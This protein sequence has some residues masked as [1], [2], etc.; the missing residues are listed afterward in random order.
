[1]IAVFLKDLRL[2]AR[3]R[4]AL[5]FALVVPILVITTI[6]AALYDRDGGPNLEILVVDE[7]RGPVASD[8]AKLL[9]NHAEVRFAER[10]EAEIAV[11]VKNQVPAA[12]V[13]PE[14]LS[15]RYLQGRPSEITLLTDPAQATGINTLKVLLLLMDKDAAALADPL[16]EEMVSVEEVNLTGNRL[17]V[18]PFEQNVPGFSLMFVLLAVVFGT[19]TGLHDE[20]DWGTLPRLLVAPA[21]F[22]WMLLG[23]LGARWL[24]GVLQMMVLLLWGRAFFG[25]SLGASPTAFLL[26]CAVVVLCAVATGLVV[27]AATDGREQAQPLGLVAVI[28]LSAIGGLWWPQDIVP[29]WLRQISPI[30]FTTYAMAGMNDLVLR[31]RGLGESGFTLGVLALYGLGLT[32]IGLSLFRARHS[33]R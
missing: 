32:V 28:V 21:G 5:V 22:T 27:A 20:R 15:R 3:D 11:G 6:A 16:A 31:D 13:F 14:G 17:A 29:D 1:M 25:I 2:I 12:I 7:D 26:L 18:T 19:A 33:A 4:L 24:L 8:F 23:K 30:A 9:G 10:G